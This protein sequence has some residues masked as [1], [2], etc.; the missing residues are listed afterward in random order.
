MIRTPLTTLLVA[1]A[2]ILCVIVMG[3]LDHPG[4][5]PAET[6]RLGYLDAIDSFDESLRTLRDRAATG[7]PASTRDAFIAARARYKRM[8]FMV[9]YLDHEASSRLNG[10][11]LPK[12]RLHGRQR[13]VYEP[14]GF[15]ILEEM[16][17]SEEFPG[18]RDE[19]V[20]TIDGML[21]AARRMKVFGETVRPS[22]RQL[23]EAIRNE[24]V[25][26]MTLGITGFDSP[27]ALN[28][29]PESK[30][31]MEGVAEAL[32][33]YLP[34]LER[35]APDLAKELRSELNGALSSLESAESFDLFDR[36][37]YIRNHGNR[38][39]SLTLRAHLALRIETYREVSFFTAPVNYEAEGLFAENALNPY[40][41]SSDVRDREDSAQAELGRLL[42][43]DP[44]LSGNDMRACASCHEP[45]RAFTDG[46]PKSV[47]FHGGS[48]ER[49]APTLVNAAFQRGN[50]YDQRV[51][52]FEDQVEAVLLNGREMGSQY[53]DLMEKLNGSPEYVERFARAFRRDPAEA[54]T[55]MTIRRAL[56][57]YMRSLVALD[58]P[59]DRFIRGESEEYPAEARRGFN[60]FMGKAKCG[61]CHFAPIFNGTVPPGY[62]E[63]EVE[64]LGVPAT[65]DTAAARLDPDP[66]RYSVYLDT[67]HMNAFKTPTVRNI[68]LTAPY[69]HNGVYVTLEE[70][71]DFYDRG[72]G[73]GMGIDVPNQTL[74]PDRLNLSAVEKGELVAFLRTLTDTTGT[75]ARPTSL[76]A[77]PRN[78]ALNRRRVAGAY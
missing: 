71:I 26:V 40:Y 10:V 42:F 24:I 6:V 1:L 22:D 73:A 45:E 63:T 29:L 27:V 12:I 30:A 31:A 69:M 35:R 23:F 65:A 77:F 25:R 46:R 62:A 17:F 2:P 76:P 18:N 5:E 44:V 4:R 64:I 48:V 53:E 57:G 52:F 14:E 33:L 55:P 43:F 11:P 15:Q 19:T 41:Y 68:E 16:I 60:L 21:A 70:V 28:S 66:G 67:I 51:E 74:P 7:D 72:G 78:P 75:T 50:F 13:V 36:A 49:N 58:A 8:E 56:A 59:F 54:I 38:L 61:T 39:Y 37:E 32:R 34:A 9:E 47:A 3:F 20:S